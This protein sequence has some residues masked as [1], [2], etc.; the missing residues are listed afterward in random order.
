MLDQSKM[1]MSERKKHRGRIQAQ[2]GGFEQ[3]KSWSQDEPL[4]KEDGLRLLNELEQ[5]L[6]ENERTLRQKPFQKAQRMIAQIN[7]GLDAQDK[8]TF[9]VR[10][11]RDIRVDVEVLSGKAFVSALLI[12]V[13]WLLI[14]RLY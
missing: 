2:G 14:K 13:G 12:W 10:R 9:L 7:G 8:I 6:P 4:S 3:S 1:L 11:T 5:E